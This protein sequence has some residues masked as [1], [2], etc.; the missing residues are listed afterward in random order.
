MIIIYDLSTNI[1]LP[2]IAITS[3]TIGFSSGDYEISSLTAIDET[4]LSFTAN[5]IGATAGPLII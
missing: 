2:P 1:D 5:G 4:L 3:R